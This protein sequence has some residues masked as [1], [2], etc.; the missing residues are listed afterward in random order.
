MT[1]KS[2]WYRCPEA[3]TTTIDIAVAIVLAVSEVVVVEGT[4]IFLEVEVAVVL[5][6]MLPPG[7]LWG[8]KNKQ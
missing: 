8:K 3:R 7:G 6:W 5:I 1:T 4:D 2:R